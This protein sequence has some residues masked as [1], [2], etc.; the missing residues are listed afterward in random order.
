M[1]IQTN[2]RNA[3]TIEARKRALYEK[4]KRN[5]MFNP[6]VRQ[7]VLNDPANKEWFDKFE[8]EEAENAKV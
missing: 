5:T 6:A 1:S 4:V 7:T 3:P 2:Y 8:R